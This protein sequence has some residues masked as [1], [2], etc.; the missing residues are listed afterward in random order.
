MFLGESMCFFVHLFGLERLPVVTRT[1]KRAGKFRGYELLPAAVCD[2]I[3]TVLT[4][5]AL[6][7]TFASH[8]AVLA[9]VNTLFTALFSVIFFKRRLGSHNWLGAMLVAV[10]AAFI[11]AC[12]ELIEQ[13]GSVAAGVPLR[14]GLP[15]DWNQAN[16]LLPSAWSVRL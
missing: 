11:G 1:S 12:S 4:N 7:Y 2:M 6:V 3:A 13:S 10:G 9:G 8:V 5:L 16:V 15:S 14:P